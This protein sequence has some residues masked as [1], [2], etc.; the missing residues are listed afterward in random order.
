MLNSMTCRLNGGLV[1]YYDA[2]PRL[3]ADVKLK[4]INFDYFRD[5]WREKQKQAGQQDFFL[6]FDKTANFNWLKKL[7]TTIDF[8]VNV[9]QFTFMDHKGDRASFR[10]FV[11]KRVWPLRYAL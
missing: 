4:D 5:V 10:V 2:H 3:E 6:K 8:K 9:D 11:K 7:Q 1:A